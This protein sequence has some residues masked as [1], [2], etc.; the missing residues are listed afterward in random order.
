M[1]LEQASTQKACP[2]GSSKPFDFCCR[3][4]IEGQKPA[5]TAEALM[6]SRYSAFS[7][8][9]I[10]YLIDTLAPEKRSPSDATELAEHA[11]HITW[12]GLEVIHCNKGTR[13]DT[14]G[15]VEFKA[16]FESE[17]ETAILCET[18]NFIKID[19]Q[20]YYVDGQVDVIYS[21]D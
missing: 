3:P 11:R 1:L 17:N 4:F 16:H 21:H 7:M 2:C 9:A 6:R 5:P 15:T 13:S 12:T 18:S 14:Q 10:D 20:W 19:K 8:G